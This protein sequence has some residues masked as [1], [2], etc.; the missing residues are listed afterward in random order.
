M[1]LGDLARQ[2]FQVFEPETD[3]RQIDARNSV[4]FAQR[5]ERSDVADRS[6]LRQPRCQAAATLF[7]QSLVEL[8]GTQRA[9]LKENP[10]DLLLRPLGHPRPTLSHDYA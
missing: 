7:G 6:L 1:L 5:L 2:Q 10:A 9:L 8:L 3:L 4:L